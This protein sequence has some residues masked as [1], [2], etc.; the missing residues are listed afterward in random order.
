MEAARH[1]FRRAMTFL[2]RLTIY[3]CERWLLTTCLFIVMLWRIIAHNYLGLMYFSGLYML[4]LLVQFYSPL[5]L[6]D[7]DEDDFGVQGPSDDNVLE[8]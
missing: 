4:Y 8:F 1:G 2:N 3:P 5:G 7:P 6:P